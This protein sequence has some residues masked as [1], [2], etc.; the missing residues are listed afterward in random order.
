MYKVY[1]PG[2]EIAQNG[3]TQSEMQYLPLYINMWKISP[4]QKPLQ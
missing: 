3:L 2:K 4:E 1:V